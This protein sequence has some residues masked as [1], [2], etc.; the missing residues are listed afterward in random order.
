MNIVWDTH[1]K[2]SFQKQI[3]RIAEDSIQNAE[4]VRSSILSMIDKI[5]ENP[6]KYPL[7]RFKV[8][9]NGMFRAFEKFSIRVVYLI[10]PDQI[11]IL[12]VRHIKQEPEN[13]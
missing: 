10:G 2:I 5:P 13:Y 7:D 6:E 3:K 9:N 1:A 8:S 11:K 12:R 4:N